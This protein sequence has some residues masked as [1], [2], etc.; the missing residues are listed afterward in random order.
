MEHWRD[1]LP[2]GNRSAK[3]DE[4]EPELPPVE[5]YAPIDG[6]LL[7]SIGTA[8]SGT[9]PKPAAPA[10]T[11]PLEQT[12][13]LIDRT[14]S[15][16]IARGASDVHFEPAADHICVR[17]R[18]DGTLVEITRLPV[19]A[20]R[21]LI[22]RLKV[23]SRLSTFE[24][25]KPQDGRVFAQIRGRS[26]DLRISFLPTIHGEK[27]A[28]RIFHTDLD[29]FDLDLL[30]LSPPLR[31]SFCELLARPQGIVFVTGPTGSGKTTTMYASLRHIKA[32]SQDMTN[33]VT[34]EDPVELMIPELSQ[35]QVNE[36]V[37]LTFA[38]GL[39]TILRQDPDVIM[40]GEIR[41]TET[42]QVALQAGLTGHLMLTTVHAD[43]SPG[44]FSRLIN[45]GIEPFLLASAAAGVL[46]QRLV[47]TLC[48]HCRK[49]TPLTE[50]ELHL[51][52]LS[53]MDLADAGRFY[54]ATGCG[55]CLGT[56]YRGRTL[57]AELMPVSEPLK[58]AIIAKVPAGE[59]MRIA[60]AHGMQTLLENGI[61]RA[62]N[63]I[64]SLAE[65][66]RVAR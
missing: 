10:V 27:A 26:Y 6:E 35:T 37:G 5:L 31:R 7:P 25:S 29:R 28:L 58:Q 52:D 40:L 23:M 18:V 42:A 38:K 9:A 66:L 19:E 32:S 34:I 56:G 36:A 12:V 30:G 11:A 61:S 49:V 62:L 47:R 14:L 44:V 43:S 8:T 54:T 50:S 65:V 17:F 3:G 39:R 63:G 22:N 55:E 20:H 24:H 4:S 64:T 33:I 21:S 48:P 16:A 53:E 41:D 57:L 59:L 60:R 13:P 15:D 1:L 45:M 2:A 51:L 46:S